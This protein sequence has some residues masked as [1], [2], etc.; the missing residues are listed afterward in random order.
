MLCTKYA[1]KRVTRRKSHS[2]RYFHVTKVF[3]ARA[4][5]HNEKYAPP[6]DSFCAIIEGRK[7]WLWLSKFHRA[8]KK[9]V[10]SIFI[11][12]HSFFF[13]YSFRVYSPFGSL[14]FFFSL[15]LS[16]VYI[17]IT[18]IRLVFIDCMVFDGFVLTNW[19][20]CCLL[21]FLFFFIRFC[22]ISVHS[23]NCVRARM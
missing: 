7:G 10:M 15:W 2:R 3:I 21:L 8:P 1:I 22:F 9:N 12:F 5:T 20:L 17:Y 19:N 14:L 13:F 6:K 18:P 4:R 11:Y 23:E 16:S